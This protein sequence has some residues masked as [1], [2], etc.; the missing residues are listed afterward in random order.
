MKKKRRLKKKIRVILSVVLGLLVFL[1]I[2]FSI[3]RV[4]DGLKPTVVEV[5]DTI[6]KYNY[7][8]DDRDN[9]LFTDYFA[10]LK[11]VLNEDNI[12]FDEYAELL[13]KMFVI[14]FYTLDNKLN[15]Y[16]VG[17]L[18]FLDADIYKGFNLKAMDTIY[19]YI[20]VIEGAPDVNFVEIV[21]IKDKNILYNE[22]TYEGYS[23]TLS[24]KY[25]KDY[26]YDTDGDVLI[27]RDGEFLKIIEFVGGN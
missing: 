21:D 2:V 6:D 9:S 12:D 22:E 18:Q 3:L 24:W 4:I 7:T 8:L 16:D 25:V 20:G 1:V 13:S 19:K 11:K 27:I 5:I 14:D 17:G 10:D 26:G 15:K 23:V